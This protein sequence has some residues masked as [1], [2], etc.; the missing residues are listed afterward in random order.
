MIHRRD[1]LR[2]N[3][4][5]AQQVLD[6]NNVE[7]VWQTVVQEIV[8]EEEVQQL[9]LRNT[10]T[11]EER[12]LPVSGVFVAIGT[13]AHTDWLEELVELDSEFIRTDTNMQTSQPGIYAAGD[14][15]DTVIRQVTTAVGDATVAAYSAYQY[16]AKDRGKAYGE[17]TGPE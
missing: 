5:L 11:E 12:L 7:P 14:V 6:R 8:G 1:R 10:E 9:R 4:Y 13:I 16:I 3:P 17:Y 15:R 2:A